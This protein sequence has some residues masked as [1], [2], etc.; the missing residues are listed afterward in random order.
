MLGTAGR[1]SALPA[2]PVDP[3]TP[4][5]TRT[6]RLRPADPVA[7]GRRAAAGVLTIALASAALFT[8]PTPARA[9]GRMG[10]RAAGKLAEGR[11]S[12]TAAAAVRDLLNPGETLADASTWA[13]EVRRQIPESA[14]WHYVNVPITEEKYSA[15]F[16]PEQ[17]CVVEKI[18]DFLRVLADPQAPRAERQKA[19]RFVAHFVQDLHQPVH[20]GHRDDRGGNDLQVQFFGKGSNL[21]RVWDS[22]LIERA[23]ADEDQ[24]LHDLAGL[25]KDS[26]DD[27]RWSGGTAE[28][29]A[30]ESLLAARDAY[31]ATGQDRELKRGE[32]LGDAYQE[33]NLPV[34]RKRLAQSAARLAGLLNAA[35]A[36]KG[37]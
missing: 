28:D 36:G 19:L 4:M 34:A 3:D 29:W 31:R 17:G 15:R 5:T 32:K 21:H 6:A 11:L 12:P 1:P 7:R 14:P 20:V 33:A 37:R 26:R 9:W 30:T 24:L 25:E 35:F 16:C 10:H 8:T 18:G 2:R 23:F 27:A 13:D 22:G